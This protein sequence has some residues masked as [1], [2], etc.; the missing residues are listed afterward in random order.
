MLSFATPNAPMAV[1]QAA[2]GLTSSAATLNGSANPNGDAAF[3]RFRY[4]S[5]DP[6]TNDT[7]RDRLEKGDG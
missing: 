4:S 3:G 1:T 5:A 7:P 2:T 6:G